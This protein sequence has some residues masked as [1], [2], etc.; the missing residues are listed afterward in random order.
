VT[1]EGWF[2]ANLA[3]PVDLTGKTVLK[4]DLQTLAAQTFTKLSIQVGDGF[5]WCEQSGG[6]GNQVQNS[7]GVVSID[8][9]NL[10]CSSPNLTKLQAVNIYLQPGTFRIDDIRAE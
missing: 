10:T 2:G 7:V 4:L 8:L 1:G 9:T 5:D 6:G 3:A